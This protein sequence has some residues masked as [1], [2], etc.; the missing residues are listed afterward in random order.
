MPTFSEIRPIKENLNH[1]LERC[2]PE[3]LIS[4]KTRNGVGRFYE[5]F[6]LIK[7]VNRNQKKKFKQNGMGG[8][9]DFTPGYWMNFFP[10]ERDK[11]E[12]TLCVKL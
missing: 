4:L 2:Q 9:K 1:D 12:V 5:Y 10:L 6:R 7:E 8:V 3:E 11:K